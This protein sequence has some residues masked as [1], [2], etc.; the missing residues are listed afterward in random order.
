MADNPASHFGRQVKK[1]R[2]ARGWSLDELARQTGI[3]AAHFSRIENGHRPPTEKIAT[4]CDA[5]FP[6]RRGWFLEYFTELQRWTEVPSWFRPWAEFEMNTATLLDWSP[7][8]LTGLLQTSDYAAAI[9][10]AEPRITP[11]KAAERVANRMA[12]Q[13]RVLFR[14]DDPPQARF[15]VDITSLRRLALGGPLMAAQLRHLLAVSELPHVTIQVVPECVHAGLLGGFTIV[16]GAAYAESVVLGQVFSDEETL[17]VLARR[18]DMLR[19]E[20]MRV[21]ESAALLREMAQHE[22]LEKVKLQRRQRR[23][24]RGDGQR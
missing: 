12:R 11:E 2:L 14:D 1:E 5:A 7:S 21:S 15:L 9:V 22:R 17:S 19:G 16:D 24:L 18:F 10:S 20:A 8:V 6:S 13:Q 4:A 3:N 23:K